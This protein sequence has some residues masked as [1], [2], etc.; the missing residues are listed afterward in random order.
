MRGLGTVT[1]AASVMLAAMSSA[2]TVE[3]LTYRDILGDWCGDDSTYHF[4][5]TEL[6][7]SFAHETV[8][9][10]LE[11]RRYEFSEEWVN[12]VFRPAGHVVFAEF[13]LDG[14]RM[15][16]QPKID[17]DNGLRREFHRC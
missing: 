3:K 6:R 16:L 8:E 15:A 11:I 1:I 17:E 13:S 12:V 9:R 5:R 7:V 10:V 14:Q 4:S 2:A